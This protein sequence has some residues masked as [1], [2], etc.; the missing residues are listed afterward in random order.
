MKHR[1]LLELEKKVLRSF[2]DG[3]KIKLAHKEEH[4]RIHDKYHH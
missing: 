3:K 2:S 4:V 1:D